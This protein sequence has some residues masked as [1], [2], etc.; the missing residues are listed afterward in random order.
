MMGSAWEARQTYQRIHALGCEAA[1]RQLADAGQQAVGADGHKGNVQVRGIH[2]LPWR[3]VLVATR[4]LHVY[5]SL[6][7]TLASPAELCNSINLKF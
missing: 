2:I 3:K 1:V 7:G 6:L 4:D 5:E